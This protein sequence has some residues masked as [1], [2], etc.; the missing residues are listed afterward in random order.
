[1]K[2]LAFIA[3]VI[4]S[5]FTFSGCLTPRK[6]DRW[7][8]QK[9]HVPVATKPKANDYI[10]IKT[11]GASSSDIVS[12]TEKRKMKLLPLFFYW[13]WEYGTISTLNQSVAGEY[14][15]SAIIPY[16]NAKKL[17]DK[18]NGQ[19]L[20]VTIDKIPC[21]FSVVDKG[22]LVF[23]IVFYV[24]WDDIFIDPE[25]QDMVISYRLFK[26]NT[27]TKTGTITITDRNKPLHVKVFHSVKKTFWS[28][29]DQYN[30]NIQ[31]MS[32]E[33]IDKLIAEL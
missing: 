1:M 18:L 25:K 30:Y 11:P 16:A 27:E 29:L 21:T 33:L 5:Q 23:F 19:K 8:D 13:K 12:R 9:Y 22:G 24:T 4:F 7:I 31:L 14:F 10:T 2:H 26:E 28:Y 20:E 32:K 17:R 15:H 3:L 6:I